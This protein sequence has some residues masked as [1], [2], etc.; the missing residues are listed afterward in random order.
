MLPMAETREAAVAEVFGVS[1]EQRQRVFYTPIEP[2]IVD[3]SR[4][5]HMVEKPQDARERYALHALSALADP[6]EIY[7]DRV[8]RRLPD[9]IHRGL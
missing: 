7:V 8:R 2:V 6:Y 1:P 3:Y 9:P 4:L 5:P